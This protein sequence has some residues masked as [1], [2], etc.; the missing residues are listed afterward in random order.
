[1]S[2]DSVSQIQ[3]KNIHN[4]IQKITMFEIHLFFHKVFQQDKSVN[5]K[6]NKYTL[7]YKIVVFFFTNIIFLITISINKFLDFYI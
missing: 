6:H 5:K 4:F 1:M 2:T 7:I 3:K